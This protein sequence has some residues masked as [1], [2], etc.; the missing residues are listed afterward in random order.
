MKSIITCTD[1][2]KMLFTNQHAQIETVAKNCEDVFKEINTYIKQ[3]TKNT[4][5][6]NKLMLINNIG[7]KVTNHIQQHDIVINVDTSD[8]FHTEYDKMT[9]V[10]NKM[11]SVSG[12]LEDL[13]HVLFVS[14]SIIDSI[15][16]QDD[17]KPGC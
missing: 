11:F 8:N 9:E 17:I 15:A 10:L 14:N 12:H 13:L 6:Y 16:G 3:L 2:D 7:L 1:V 5:K 4:K